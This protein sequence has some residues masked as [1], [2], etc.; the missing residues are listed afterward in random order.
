[1]G[2]AASSSSRVRTCSRVDAGAEGS[3]RSFRSRLRVSMEGPLAGRGGGSADCSARLGVGEERG[4]GSPGPDGFLGSG[5]RPRPRRPRGPSGGEGSPQRCIVSVSS[6]PSPRVSRWS[7]SSDGGTA[8]LAMISTRTCCWTSQRAR[9]ARMRFWRKL[10]GSRGSST[11]IRSGS[12][13]AMVSRKRL[14][15]WRE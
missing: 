7:H 11:T 13:R 12:L 14:S 2:G 15:T 8:V 9:T 5:A 3:V 4:A 6:F 1:M 10:A